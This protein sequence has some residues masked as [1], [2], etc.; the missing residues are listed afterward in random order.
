MVIFLQV[1]H[2]LI[3]F[4]HYHCFK[5]GII[6]YS[7]LGTQN[8]KQKCFHLILMHQRKSRIRNILAEHFICRNAA[9]GNF[10]SFSVSVW[11]FTG[12]GATQPTWEAES[13]SFVVGFLV[14]SAPLIF[15]EHI[16]VSMILNVNGYINLRKF[17]EIIIKY[18]FMGQ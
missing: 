18:D 14:G 17:Q 9:S 8:H 7:G 11:G 16:D 10:Y 4:S 12:R 2:N 15:I 6:C 3:T 5:G 1:D 13:I